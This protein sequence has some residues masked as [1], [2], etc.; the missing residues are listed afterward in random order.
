MTTITDLHSFYK[1]KEVLITGGC[2]SIG[3]EI[4]RQLISLGVRIIKVF[5]NDEESHFNL[6]H[7]LESDKLRHLLGDVRT[8][9]RL[10]FA[11]KNVD[12]IFH[13][14][15]LKH[16]PLCEYNPFEALQTNVIGTQN[17]LDSARE[18]RVGHFVFISTDKAVNPINTMGATKLLGEKLT[19]N[20][21]LGDNITKFSCVRFG[22]VLGSSGSVLPIFTRQISKGGPVTLTSP[23]MTRFCMSLHDAVSLILRVPLLMQ[24]KEIF[25][26]KMNA[27]KVK[28]L[29]EALVEEL[30]P[31]NGYAPK[32]ILVKE[33]GIR[34]GGKL[35]ESL[36]SLDEL[37]FVRVVD[38]MYVIHAKSN[39][40]YFAEHLEESP[41][42]FDFAQFSSEHMAHLTKDQIK[43]FLK[44]EELI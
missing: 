9:S 23:K 37:P 5:D 35:H 24:G 40:P 16:V 26:L 2:G 20:A 31:R 7:T 4:A 32:S 11:M 15:A 38:D 41:H 33:I 1:D 18:N 39:V 29:A 10:D 22:N 21:D 30:A 13:A 25:I 28:D 43:E 12:I 27:L 14:A 17:V 3:S 6:Q 42:P 19:L 34:P 36:L 8:K 44:H